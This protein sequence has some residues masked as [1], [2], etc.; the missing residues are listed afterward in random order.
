YDQ[1]GLKEAET[2]VLRGGEKTSQEGEVREVSSLK[3]QNNQR[4]YRTF[5]A[6]YEGEP[7]KVIFKE[8]KQREE[9]ILYPGNKFFI[10]GEGF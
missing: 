1:S 3:N 2:V 5:I 7:L 4:R 10:E 8:K 9:V 6:V